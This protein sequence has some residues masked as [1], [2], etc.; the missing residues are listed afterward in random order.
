MG[1]MPSLPYRGGKNIPTTE[2]SANSGDNMAATSKCIHSFI[3]LCLRSANSFHK[4]PDR[5][6]SSGG[7]NAF[8]SDTVV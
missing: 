1:Q 3:H 7:S 8:N 6:F 2:S 5:K 4:G